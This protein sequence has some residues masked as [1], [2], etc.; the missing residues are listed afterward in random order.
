MLNLQPE[1]QFKQDYFDN[2][3]FMGTACLIMGQSAGL[4]YFRKHPVTAHNFK[5]YSIAC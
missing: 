1:D 3:D 5:M 2:L 4:Y